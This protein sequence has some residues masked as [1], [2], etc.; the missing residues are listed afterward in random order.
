MTIMLH[1]LTNFVNDVEGGLISKFIGQERRKTKSV[2]ETSSDEADSDEEDADL[3]PEVLL[4]EDA[5]ISF[6][7]EDLQQKKQRLMEA[8]R[9]LKTFTSK[10]TRAKPV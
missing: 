5:E 4:R 7:R 9:K 10:G 6:K 8:E 2:N 3:T 1:L